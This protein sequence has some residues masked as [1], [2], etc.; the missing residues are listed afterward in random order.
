MDSGI[1]HSLHENIRIL[2][3]VSKV[4]LI[5]AQLLDVPYKFYEFEFYQFYGSFVSNQ[6]FS[7]NPFLF[8]PYQRLCQIGRACEPEKVITIS[9]EMFALKNIRKNL[10]RRRH[11]ESAFTNFRPLAPLVLDR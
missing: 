1:V 2:L 3:S 4:V 6:L 8:T 5:L 11:I 9:K 10:T 7:H